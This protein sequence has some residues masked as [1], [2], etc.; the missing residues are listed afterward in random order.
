MLRELSPQQ[1]KCIPIQFDPVALPFEMF[2]PTSLQV[3]IP[4]FLNPVADRFLSEVAAGFLALDPFMSVEVIANIDPQ[5]SLLNGSGDHEGFVGDTRLL[6]NDTSH[7]AD[8][9]S[10][11]CDQPSTPTRLRIISIVILPSFN[12]SC[13]REGLSC[14]GRLVVISANHISA[15]D[16]QHLAGDVTTGFAGQQEHGADKFIRFAP[17]VKCSPTSKFGLFR[18]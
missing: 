6:H 12:T 18:R 10:Y 5:A 13:K 2:Q 3:T 14:D 8:R 4:V 16:Y 7:A 17:T 1:A 9:P 15:I 11:R